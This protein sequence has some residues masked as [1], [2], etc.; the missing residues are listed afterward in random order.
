MENIS[1]WVEWGFIALLTGS[2]GV[3]RK[4]YDSQAKKIEDLEK[5]TAI[6]DKRTAIIETKMDSQKEYLD[7]KFDSIDKKMDKLFDR[8]DQYDRD[9][10]EFFKSFELTPKK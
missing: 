6:I 5:E 9:R 8:F 7:Q 3:V 1:D 4:V 10:E 2:L